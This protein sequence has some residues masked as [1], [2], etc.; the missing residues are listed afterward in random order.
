MSDNKRVSKKQ[1][2]VTLQLTISSQFAGEL[3]Q[4]AKRENT[5]RNA[6]AVKFMEVGLSEWLGARGLLGK[7]G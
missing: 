3:S 1:S 4:V 2:T 6:L 5:T 7:C